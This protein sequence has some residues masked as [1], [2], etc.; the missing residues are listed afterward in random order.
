MKSQIDPVLVRQM[1]RDRAEAA[2]TDSPITLEEWQSFYMN[3][4]ERF[5][6]LEFVDDETLIHIIKQAE[7]H[8]RSAS[9]PVTYE[10]VVLYKYLPELLTRF[11]ALCNKKDECSN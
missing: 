1:Y 6:L 4:Y 9:F 10:E 3:S 2:K 8:I 11:Q 5:F 7:E